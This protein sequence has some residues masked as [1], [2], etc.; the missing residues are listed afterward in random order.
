LRVTIRGVQTQNS[1]ELVCGKIRHVLRNINIAQVVQGFGGVRSQL[2]CFL[3]RCNGSGIVLYIGFDNPQKVVAIHA[4]RISFEFF[5]HSR[6]GLVKMALPE[7]FLLLLED[8][9]GSLWRPLLSRK[10]WNRN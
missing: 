4:G 1:L 9:G 2:Q 8:N 3:E 10:S 6:F 7:Q 5:Q